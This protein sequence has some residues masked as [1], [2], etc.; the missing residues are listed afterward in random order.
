MFKSLILASLAFG[1]SAQAPA[2]QRPFRR[3]RGAAGALRRHLTFG[4]HHR[5]ETLAPTEPPSADET[6]TP[7]TA[8][9]KSP[10]AD[11]TPTPSAA[12]T[13]SPSAD[14]TP[15]PSTAPTKSP[16]A[17]NGGGD[18][19]S[20]CT[21]NVVPPPISGETYNGQ[22][23]SIGGS[24]TVD[25][26]QDGTCW[27]S[28]GAVRFQVAEKTFVAGDSCDWPPFD[29]NVFVDPETV[30][31]TDLNDCPTG[32]ADSCIEVTTVVENTCITI[33][34]GGVSGPPTPSPYVYRGD[35]IFVSNG[36]K[37]TH[38]TIENGGSAYMELDSVEDTTITVEA[39]GILEN[40]SAGTD[41]DTSII[42][43]T[44]ATADFTSAYKVRFLPPGPGDTRP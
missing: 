7:S 13:K 43:K 39:G 42:V 31:C 24:V 37:N 29:P 4:T 34:A 6:P 16:S 41:L 28:E 17:D 11:D 12:P 36:A 40:V 25:V 19:C 8:P 9:T 1:V 33:G 30:E 10:S 35:G 26:Q 14:E 27:L 23:S 44:G 32:F 15:T 21:P 5:D 20:V 18:S 22:Y 3:L 38:I 2:R